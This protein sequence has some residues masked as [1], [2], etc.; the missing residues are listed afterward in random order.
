MIPGAPGP[1]TR[2]RRR[3]LL[4]PEI[5][6]LIDDRFVGSCTLHEEYVFRLAL[7]VFAGLGLPEVFRR[8]ATVAEAIAAAGLDARASTVPLDWILRQ[9]AA[10]SVLESSSEDGTTRYRL[11]S[12]LPALDPGEIKDAQAA[13]D[14]SALPSYAIADLAAQHYPEVLRGQTT[15]ERVL[16]APARVG[17][18]Y[19]YFSN[20]NPLYAVVN[21]IGAIACEE[22]LPPGRGAILELGGGLGS[23]A[24]AVLS[25]LRAVGR[26]DEV[27]SYRFTDA[28]LPFLRK[29]QAALTQSFPGVPLSF[30]YVD[31]NRP[32]DPKVL[33][34]GAFALVHG[35]NT[36]HVAH[37]LTFTLGEIHRVLAPG[38]RI[39][40]SE[41]VRPFPGRPVYVEFVFNL[42]ESF[43]EPRLVSPWR[44]NGGFLTP[45]QWGGALRAAGFSDVRLV[46]DIARIREVYPT[47]VAG[48]IVATRA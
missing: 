26:L 20:D 15:G 32:F 19:E 18:W 17:A 9:L 24:A 34:A 23:G 28:S 29:G 44:P 36:L 42:V 13:H 46:P 1:G 30:A 2:D 39:V 16:F 45:E 25:R 7:G 8:S 10:R 47:F 43:R 38:G 3:E 12:E 6:S 41:C 27:N 4:A 21:A 48:S 22:A 5:L 40:V 33:D 35:V 11:G 37:D 14:P 31:M